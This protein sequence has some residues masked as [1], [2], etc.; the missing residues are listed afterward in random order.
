MKPCALILA[1]GRGGR[2][3]MTK[4]FVEIHKLPLF[5]YTVINFSSMPCVITIPE[6]DLARAKKMVKDSGVQGKIYLIPGGETRQESIRAGL[7]FINSKLNCTHV[8]I[9]DGC[10]PL[11]RPDTIQKCL[12][13]LE[14]NSAVVAVSKSIN[15]A[16]FSDGQFMCRVIPRQKMYDLMMP[17]CFLLD[18][19]NE[20]YALTTLEDSTDDTQIILSVYPKKKISVVQIP[21]W[22]GIKLTY[23]EDYKIFS[24]LLREVLS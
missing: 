13:A 21:F 19:L 22:E 5:M 14:K 23:A 1:A 10:R 9:T 8:L 24:F 11:I 2:F 7:K 20:C 18:L 12:V 17:Q 16:C 3:G 6:K 4:Q 15:T